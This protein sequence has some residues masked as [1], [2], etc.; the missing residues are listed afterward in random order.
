[1]AK[2]QPLQLSNITLSERLTFCFC[3]NHFPE[4]FVNLQHKIHQNIS[5][6]QYNLNLP[7]ERVEF[8]APLD[9]TQVISEA[10]L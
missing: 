8:N 7:F 10:D 2:I 9:T 1:M 6:F 5:Y 4:T 3:V